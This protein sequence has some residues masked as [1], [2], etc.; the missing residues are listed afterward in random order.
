VSLLSIF[1]R[2]L[3]I[4]LPDGSLEL[5]RVE[6]L[7]P[8]GAGLDKTRRKMI[9]EPAVQ[10]TDLLVNCTS[11]VSSRRG[12]DLDRFHTYQDVRFMASKSAKCQVELLISFIG[13]G[14]ARFG[15]VSFRT[16]VGYEAALPLELSSS[17]CGHTLQY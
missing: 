13:Q 5:A 3:V 11:S 14:F 16:C 1:V 17:G 8:A 15:C 2:R 6:P 7:A 10:T 9:D 4:P 12:D